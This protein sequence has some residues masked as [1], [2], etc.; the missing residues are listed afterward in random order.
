MATFNERLNTE[1]Q[2]AARKVSDQKRAGIRL[3]RGIVYALVAVITAAAA[4]LVNLPATIVAGLVNRL[5]GNQLSMT[6]AA[7]SAWHGRA[8]FSMQLPGGPLSLPNL[9][10][11]IQASR[12]LLGELRAE[13]NL[14]APELSGQATVVRSL[15]ATHLESVSL[16]VPA[17][18]LVQR[19][20]L[21]RPWEPNGL[22]QIRMRAADLSAEKMTADGEILVREVTT[23]KLGSL[24]EYKV[25][26]TPRGNKTALKI[27]TV[28]G[29]L[30]L[31]G[32]G[33][34]GPGGELRLAG[35]V[36]TLPADRPRLAPLLIMLGPQR[37]DGTIAFQWPLFGAPGPKPV[38]T[39]RS[40]GRRALG[41][42]GGVQ[43][44]GGVQSGV[45]DGVHSELQRGERSFAPGQGAPHG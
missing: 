29:A 30:Q 18:W 40:E 17:A 34:L 9:Q 7:G 43:M 5:A 27:G 36:G 33:E 32:T 37:A 11:K 12:L 1:R 14:A 3:K 22:V 26:A 31:D 13:L 41:V 20:P 4:S 16:N 15:Y 25:T 8:D 45:K 23:S 6:N 42:Q 44:R 35:S 24:G 39:P 10:W 19:A 2:N 38:A 28:S 21:L